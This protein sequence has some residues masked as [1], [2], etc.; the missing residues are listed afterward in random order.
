VFVNFF[1]VADNHTSPEWHFSIRTWILGLALPL[2]P[3]GVI[4]TLKVLV[5][6]SAIAT[7]FILV[8]LGCTITW[9]VT[10]IS[11]F[12]DN[13][14]LAASVA[15]PDIGSRPWIAPITQIP[16]FFATGVFAMEGIGTVSILNHCNSYF[17][18]IHISFMVISGPP[19]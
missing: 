15:L 11:P 16:L 19:D 6:L 14:T 3:L 5:P 17:S 8:G 18:I 1:Q 9:V 4:R 2:L 12:V 13:K 7:A 10:G